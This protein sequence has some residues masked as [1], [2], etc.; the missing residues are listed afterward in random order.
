MNLPA[1]YQWLLQE[2]GPRMIIEGLKFYGIKEIKGQKSNPIIIQWAKDFGIYH[3]Y[4]N[5]D[6]AWCALAHAAVAKN[7]GKPVPFRGYELLRAKSWLQWGEEVPIGEQ[8]YGDTV[9]FK[10]PKGYHVGLDIGEDE[11]CIHTM[12]GN[13]GDMYCIVR[14]PKSRLVGVRRLYQVAMPPNIR[15]INLYPTG[16]ISTDEL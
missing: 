1:Q 6:D 4:K 10:R 8:M 7:A 5:D 13:Q 11:D 9:I 16:A 15:K 2:P 14:M 3:I 12:G